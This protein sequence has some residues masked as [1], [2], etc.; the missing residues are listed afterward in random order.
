MTEELRNEITI[1]HKQIDTSSNMVIKETEVTFRSKSDS[2]D[3]LIKLAKDNFPDLADNKTLT[4][5]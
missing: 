4:K 3:V 1:K 5:K 2:V